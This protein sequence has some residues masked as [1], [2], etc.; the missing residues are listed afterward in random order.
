[1]KTVDAYI[2]TD[3]PAKL[4]SKGVPFVR[5]P[6]VLVVDGVRYNF[7]GQD[8]MSSAFIALEAV[9]AALKASQC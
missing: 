2:E 5:D 8:G 6:H 3:R 7:G 1:M 9:K 4:D